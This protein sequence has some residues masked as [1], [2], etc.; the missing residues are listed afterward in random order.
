MDARVS[1]V[2]PFYNEE[3]NVLPL[4]QAVHQALNQV[5]FQWEL[6][7]INDGS[8]DSTAQKIKQGIEQFGKHVRLIDLTR[9]F[10]QTAAMQAGIDFARGE[11]IVTMDGDLQNDPKD[12]PKMVARLIQ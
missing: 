7:L 9:N 1:V 12:I 5:D 3:D 8:T 2:V 4:I 11:I 6:L 10:K